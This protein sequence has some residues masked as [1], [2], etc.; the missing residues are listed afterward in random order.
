MSYEGFSQ[1]LC[2]NGHYW[3]DDCTMVAPELKD[4]MCLICGNPAIWENMVNTTNGSF[5]TDD[6]G[7]ELIDSKGSPIRIDGYVE[8]KVKDQ[9]CCKECKSIL[10]TTYH[11]PVKR[12][13]K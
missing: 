6:N 5:D 9:Q 8:L 11:I 7:K 4:N 3:R 2:K 12:K 10:E 1:F 13:R